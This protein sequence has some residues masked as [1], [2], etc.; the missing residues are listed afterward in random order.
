MQIRYF[1]RAEAKMRLP[2]VLRRAPLAAKD[3]P[4]A[5]PPERHI[6]RHPHEPLQ[7]PGTV[8]IVDARR[9]EARR[10]KGEPRSGVS[11]AIT[12]FGG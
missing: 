3:I 2:Q 10:G 6:R 9:P 4:T 7:Y 12:P 8:Q 11:S 5:N 1:A